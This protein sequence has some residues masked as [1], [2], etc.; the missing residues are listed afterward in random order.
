M[1]RSLPIVIGVVIILL[2]GGLVYLQN[3]DTIAPDASADTN[4]G[5]SASG[6]ESYTMA[7]VEEHG[8]DASCWTVIDGGVYDLTRWI[9]QHPGGQAAI[10][11]ICGIDGTAAFR[12]QHDHAQEQENILA[13]FKI[14][15]LSQ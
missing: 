14:G 3:R 6:T 9:S 11:S 13:T 2:V 12:G 5:A 7:E 15:T 10:E 1:N 4:T 8:D